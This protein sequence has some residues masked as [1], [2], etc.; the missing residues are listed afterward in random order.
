MRGGEQG[1]END[2]SATQDVSEDRCRELDSV[3]MDGVDF[4]R[5]TKPG[6][7]AVRT[8]FYN[9]ACPRPPLSVEKT[10]AKPT[11]RPWQ[12]EQVQGLN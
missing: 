10:C 5:K 8:V 1:N 7:R 4:E 9:I 6:E 3:G 11:R 12:K 2:Q